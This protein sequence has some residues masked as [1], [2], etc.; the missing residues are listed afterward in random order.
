MGK[1]LEGIKVVEVAMWAF[2]PACGGMLSDLGADVVKVEPP[3]GDP[4][5]G[6]AIGAIGGGGKVDLSWESY[7][8]G[9]KSITLDLKQEAGREVL[10]KLCADADVFL[11]NLLPPARKSMGIDADTIRGLFPNIIYASGSP[12]GPKGPDS[13][14]GGYDSIS[15]WA[16]GG[17]S[18]SLTED[19]AEYPVGP[20]GPAFGDTLSGSMLCGAIC[21]AIAK[22]AMTGEPSTVDVSLLGTAMWSMQRYIAQSTMDGTQKFPRPKAPK[23]YN[24]L[25]GNYRTADDRFV[26]LCMLQ[27]DKY[28]KGFCEVAGKPEWVGDPRYAD[29]KARAANVDACYA[30]MKALLASKTLAE[31]KD[32]L[33]RQDGQW[34]PVQDVGELQH[35]VQVKANNFVQTVDYGDG[36]TIPLVAVPY[37][38]D[39]EPMPARRSPELGADSDAILESLGYD[40][41]CIIDL[42]VQGVVF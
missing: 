41:D 31:W 24:V 17:V 18:S 38:F 27:A 11:T 14:K 34:D 6:L 33:G 15:F 26:S 29:A 8:R 3:S 5:R 23:P 10:R 39:G 1:P 7:N 12:T 4:L 28:W 9:K 32:I 13:A 25:V 21:A 22:R 40:E 20:P 36:S 2:V 16:R 37:V 19:D 42:K 35:D 30:D